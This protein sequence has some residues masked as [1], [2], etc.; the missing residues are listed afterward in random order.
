MAKPKKV[1]QGEKTRAHLVAVARGLFAEHGFAATSTEDV[2]H[3]AQVTRGAL[4]HHFKDKEDLFEAVFEELEMELTA[5]VVE[6]ALKGRTPLT[7]LR[8]GLSAFLERC[9]DPAVQ[10]IVLRDGLAV[11][12]WD[13]WYEIDVRYALGTIAAGV[14][15]AMDAGEI[16]RQ[17]VEPLAHLVLGAMNHA[18]MYIAASQDPEAARKEMERGLR[19]LVDGLR[20]P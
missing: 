5:G 8:R 18:G 7:Q 6:T 16:A 11:L 20:T 12:G 10:R 14:Q 17:P 1:E 19:R 3:A 4:Y 2:V 13:R 9:L 15:T